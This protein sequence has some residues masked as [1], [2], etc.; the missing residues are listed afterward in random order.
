MTDSSIQ[1]HNTKTTTNIKVYVR[2]R[3]FNDKE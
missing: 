3:P 2:V 1:P